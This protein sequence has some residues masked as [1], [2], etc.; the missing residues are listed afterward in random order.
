MEMQE[1]KLKRFNIY[2]IITKVLFI[3]SIVAIVLWIIIS[4][5]VMILLAVRGTEVIMSIQDFVANLGFEYTLP[6]KEIPYLVVF[7]LEISTL[8]AIILTSYVFRALSRIFTNIVE[9]KT[10][11]VQ[12][13]NRK[14]KRIGISMFIFTGVQLILSTALSIEI[15]RLFETSRFL[16]DGLSVN[17]AMIGFGILVLALAEIFEFG[18]DLQLDS[19]S[20]V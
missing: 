1:K 19:K 3:L 5:L 2:R 20:I 16:T 13:N 18:T 17:W 11:F 8:A 6:L 15:N 14:V 4:T 12:D 9:A 10:P 7:L